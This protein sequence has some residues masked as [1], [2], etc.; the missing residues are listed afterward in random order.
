MQKKITDIIKLVKNQN[1]ISSIIVVILMVL[2]IG[3]YLIYRNQN[4]N[5]TQSTNNQIASERSVS[6]DE[7]ASWELYTNVKNGY[8]IKYPPELRVEHTATEDLVIFVLKTAKGNK[9][10]VEIKDPQVV[11]AILKGDIEERYNAL[12]AER[13]GTDISKVSRVEVDIK[14]LGWMK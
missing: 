12:K 8:S 14:H 5:L 7:V 9:G 11:V 10:G 2:S 6:A 4:N 3:G 1:G 13:E